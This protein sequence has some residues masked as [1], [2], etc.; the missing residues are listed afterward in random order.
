MNR[1]EHIQWC[2]KRA[3]E[4]V[5]SREIPQAWSSMVS[6]LSKHDETQEHPAISLG[7]GMLMMGKLNTKQ[8][9]RRF[10]EGFN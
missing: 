2:K 10:I 1:T 7:M 4:Y 3:L 6:D 8:E 9:M 5:D